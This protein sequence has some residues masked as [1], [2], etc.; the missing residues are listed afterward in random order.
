MEVQ[1]QVFFKGINTD[2]DRVFLSGDSYI[3]LVN[4]NLVPTS[5]GKYIVRNANGTSNLFSI[6]DGFVVIGFTV[7]AGIL[8]IVSNNGSDTEIG[9]YPYVS[10]GVTTN[11][12]RALPVYKVNSYSAVTGIRSSLFG[13]SMTSKVSVIG[14]LTFDGTVNLYLCDGLNPNWI[15]N[16][17]FDQQGASTGIVYMP[18]SFKGRLRHFIT[19]SKIPQFV[20]ASSG[21]QDGGNL[22]PGSYILFVRYVDQHYNRTPFL[23]NSEPFFV[24]NGDGA[25]QKIFVPF[26]DNDTAT[27]GKSIKAYLGNLEGDEYRYMEIAYLR[28]F[29]LTDSVSTEVKLISV[30]YDKGSSTALSIVITG[31]EKTSTLTLEELYKANPE[32]QASSDHAIINDRYWAVGWRKKKRSSGG[33]TAEYFRRIVPK[34]IISTNSANCLPGIRYDFDEVIGFFDSQIYQFVGQFIYS[35]MTKS[36]LF[37]CAGYENPLAPSYNSS[38]YVRIRKRVDADIGYPIRV[39]MDPTVVDTNGHF[40]DSVTG[41]STSASDYFNRYASYDEFK[42]VIGVRFYRS[43]RV[44]NLLYQGFAIPTTFRFSASQNMYPHKDATAGTWHGLIFSKM[45]YLSFA[46]TALEGTKSK[47]LGNAQSPQSYS[48]ASHYPF[49]RAFAPGYETQKSNNTAP[50]CLCG[51]FDLN[52][53]EKVKLALF[54]PDFMLSSLSKII[55]GQ[56]LYYDEISDCNEYIFFPDEDS[57]E[58]LPHYLGVRFKSTSMG[59]TV[60][61]G[62]VIA[63]PVDVDNDP[64]SGNG[65]FISRIRDYFAVG[66][67]KTALALRARMSYPGGN[68]SGSIGVLRS[69]KTVRYI[70]LELQNEFYSGSFNKVEP[71]Y[72]NLYLSPNDASFYNSI[73]LQKNLLESYFP[74]GGA[75]NI[76][77]ITYKNFGGDC[78]YGFTRF[79]L[80]KSFEFGG[81]DTMGDP[82]AWQKQ[83]GTTEGGMFTDDPFGRKYHFG[84]MAEVL[85]ENEIFQGAR[86]S[87]KEATH[88]DA[89]G[90]SFNSTSDLARFAKSSSKNICNE[91]LKSYGGLSATSFVYEVGGAKLINDFDRDSFLSGAVF[92]DRQIG[93]AV[94]DY[95]RN[96]TLTKLKTFDM[97]LGG[98]VAIKEFGGN[99]LMLHRHGATLHQTELLIKQTTENNPITIA[100]G[101][102][103]PDLYRRVGNYGVA[104]SDAAIVTPRAI[105]GFDSVKER[106]WVIF[107]EDQ[108]L[109]QVDLCEVSS[110]KGFWSSMINFSDQS[111]GVSIVDAALGYDVNR[112]EVHFSLLRSDSTRMTFIYSEALKAFTCRVECFSSHLIGFRNGLLSATYGLSS[113]NNVV[114][115]MN[116]PSQSDYQFF[117]G[118]KKLF[119]FVFVLNGRGEKDFSRIPKVYE[120]IHLL[121]SRVPFRQIKF[122]TENQPGVLAIFYD[123]SRADFW[124]NP[125]WKESKWRVPVS[126]QTS[127]RQDVG[128]LRMSDHPEYPVGAIYGFDPNAA[129]R[130]TWLEVEINYGGQGNEEEIYIKGVESHFN[131]SES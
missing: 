85:T 45:K 104:F 113:G 44:N 92:S 128:P 84:V 96:I 23:N 121:S 32:T 119:R 72:I 86:I 98:I 124:N 125:D 71:R 100:Q 5:S 53:S 33:K 40:V 4:G 57:C 99:I 46:T 27:T 67:N 47:Y 3:D 13:Y 87:T 10:N 19:A 11:A 41:T 26:S 101:E 103:L 127:A 74:M 34:S 120:A 60:R 114:Y 52:Y 117:H 59:A 38:G 93:D 20:M 129:Q 130:G 102:V 49:Y 110:A 131:V 1:E 83:Y 107:R 91:N 77:D 12:Y 7:I 79:A 21:M 76:G 39:T 70:G 8:Y 73:I 118:Q 18:E 80:N 115:R 36:D 95:F 61:H 30:M 31:R 51:E 25:G 62:D 6:P 68:Q 2:I 94:S 16:T 22:K 108:S 105:Y 42:D 109:M 64:G 55:P 37:P 66:K 17:G 35:D 15:V 112:E 54:S 122:G 28:S 111:T 78:F 106:P 58:V 116:S 65:N 88:F 89:C 24:A 123:E 48:S 43:K 97:S 29:G 63:Y 81:D 9:S 126:V 56:Q 90:F 69:N 75:F 82:E 50:W 14:R